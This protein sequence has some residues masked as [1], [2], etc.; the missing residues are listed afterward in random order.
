MA[1]VKIG[2]AYYNVDTDRYQDIRIKRL[3]KEFRCDGIAVYDYILCEIYRV[4]GCFILWD[5]S[6]AFDVAEYF[7][8]K[9]TVVE[10]IVSYCCNVGLF[11]KELRASGSVLTSASIQR[12]YADMCRRA[13]RTALNIPEQLLL[14]NNAPSDSALGQN[15]EK[16]PQNS[17]NWRQNSEKCP[18]NSPRLPQ[19]KVKKRKENISFSSDAARDCA[20]VEEERERIFEIFKDRGF[21]DPAG[22]VERFY[23]YYAATGWKRGGT[24]IVDRIA[25]ARGWKEQTDAGGSS[26]RNAPGRLLTYSE[27]IDQVSR[28]NPQS[29]YE[30]VR[31]PGQEK[32][33][34]RRKS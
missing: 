32:P 14:L 20:P 18:Q 29:N 5:E 33:M 23:T 12:R 1:N 34:W 11:D 31:V 27:M 25:L 28:A 2:L 17:E 8:L 22:S 7:G 24:K 26:G 13:G 9:E 3:K 21:T 19:S 10:E 4:K 15:S 6:T 16:C 30:A